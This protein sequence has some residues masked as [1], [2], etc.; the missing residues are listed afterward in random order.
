MASDKDHSVDLGDGDVAVLNYAYA[1]E[2]LEAEFYGRVIDNPFKGL[3]SQEERTFVEIR[4]HEIAHREFLRK[5]LG[6]QAISAIDVDFSTINFDDRANVLGYADTFEN[7]GVAAF[8]GAGHLIQN[9]D[10]L[11]AAGTI[12]SVEA[13]HT[14]MI[15]TLL[16]GP[17]AASAGTGHI[18]P[19]G[20]DMAMSP[21]EV[22][23]RAKQ[24]IKSPLTFNFPG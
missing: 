19:Q 15:A 6:G 7:L 18:S 20:L 13:R 11:A 21:K 22:L 8:N 9:V 16:H 10:Y 3:T 12:V 23:A 1:L 14:A 24:F 2:Q 4:D 5:A 17:S